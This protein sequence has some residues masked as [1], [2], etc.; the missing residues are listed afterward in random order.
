MPTKILFTPLR[1]LLLSITMVGVAITLISSDLLYTRASG[2]QPNVGPKQSYMALGDSLA[3]GYQPN[4]DFSHGYNVNLFAYLQKQ[5]VTDKAF[6]GCPG[7]TSQTFIKGGCPG[8]PAGSPSQLSQAISYIKAHPGQISPITFQLGA[9]D[10][11]HDIDS[12]TCKVN[13]TQ[14]QTDLANLDTNLTQTIL[15]Q[16]SDALKGEDGKSTADILFPNYYDPFQNICPSDQIAYLQQFNE[17]LAKDVSNYGHVVDLFGAF[18]GT[19]K[20]NANTDA[21]IWMNSQYKDIHPNTDGISI[22]YKCDY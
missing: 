22:Y 16:L 8:A 6:L 9:N 17:H 2:I 19:I 7:E 15:P 3:F 11:L 5:G 13:T 21:L 20:P 4:K 1:V 18:G 14:F 12:T 10:V